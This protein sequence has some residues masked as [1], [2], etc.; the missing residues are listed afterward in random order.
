MLMTVAQVQPVGGPTATTELSATTGEPGGGL[1]GQV[2]LG[3]LQTNTVD[4]AE[5]LGNP[6]ALSS[7]MM[8]GLGNLLQ[9]SETINRLVG[10]DFSKA[11]ARVN[12]REAGMPV[13]SPHAGDL[14]GSFAPH[15][16][17]G[18]SDAGL[19]GGGGPSLAT[20][21]LPGPAER[22]PGQSNDPRWDKL[23]DS[24]DRA[25]IRYTE[26]AAYELQSNELQ[27]ITEQLSNAVNSLVRA[28]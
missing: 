17:G 14:V 22:H 21:P 24:Y 12:S 23:Q 19:T 27:K 11:M 1:S 20:P 5:K 3:D 13:G 7:Q 16:V 26:F 10:D 28:S 6:A 25:F 9:Q 2:N 15:A 4:N 8:G 18:L